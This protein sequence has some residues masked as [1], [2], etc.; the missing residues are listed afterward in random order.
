MEVK[1]N[2]VH[3][4]AWSEWFTFVLFGSFQV[5]FL[6][7]FKYV[8]NDKMQCLSTMCLISNMGK[9]TLLPNKDNLT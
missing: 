9:F 5:L 3:R 8:Q 2:M 6:R 4:V 7:V 1:K